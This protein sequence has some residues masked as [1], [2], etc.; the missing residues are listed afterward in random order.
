VKGLAQ[1]LSVIELVH[2]T[3]V[4]WVIGSELVHKF[5]SQIL[6]P[7]DLRNR[8]SGLANKP[9]EDLT[10]CFVSTPLDKTASE[11]LQI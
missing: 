10:G 9:L 11:I 8:V 5:P 1:V 6:L 4:K 3:S 2:K 7:P